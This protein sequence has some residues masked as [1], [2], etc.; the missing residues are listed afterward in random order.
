MHRQFA[1][2]TDGGPSSEVRI[3]VDS[4]TVDRFYAS[5][6]AL[7]GCSKSAPDSRSFP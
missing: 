6:L 4:P 3:W 2:A 7:C 1:F 5:T